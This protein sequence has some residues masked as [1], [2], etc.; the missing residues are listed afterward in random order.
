[1]QILEAQPRSTESDLWGRGV[2]SPVGSP[3]GVSDAWSGLRAAGQTGRDRQGAKLESEIWGHCS[4]PPAFGQ[5]FKPLCLAAS[6]PKDN[7]VVSLPSPV[8]LERTWPRDS[9]SDPGYCYRMPG[10]VLISGT[11]HPDPTTHEV[12]IITT[13]D[14]VTRTPRENTVCP[15]PCY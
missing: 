15:R 5:V 7:T 1:M 6:S 11:L 4:G 3:P 9:S 10:G 12:S 2:P 8:P 13:P 14:V